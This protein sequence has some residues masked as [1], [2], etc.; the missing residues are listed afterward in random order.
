MFCGRATGGG[1]ISLARR[2]RKCF[3]RTLHF[4]HSPA[5]AT[6]FVFFGGRVKMVPYTHFL[7]S[8]PQLKKFGV[9]GV[10]IVTYIHICFFFC[11]N[12]AIYTHF[13]GVFVSKCYHIYIF[14]GIF[15]GKNAVIYTHFWN[16]IFYEKTKEK[17]NNT[18]YVHILLS[19]LKT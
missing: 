13:G 19:D 5:G 14:W 15:L 16:L 4:L 3:E 18:I 7:H 11:R 1:V 8:P 6:N 17:K 10:K 9:F 12:A 2:R